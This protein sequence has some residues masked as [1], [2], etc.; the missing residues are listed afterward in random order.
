MQKQKTL[1]VYGGGFDPPH[2]GHDL[3]L[4]I[5]TQTVDHVLVVPCGV[6][7][8]KKASQ[9]DAQTRLQWC[10][11]WLE[12]YGDKVS[13]IDWE[14]TGQLS[15]LTCDLVARVHKEFPEWKRFVAIG[16]DQI[17]DFPSWRGNDI[18]FQ[19]AEL[20]AIKRGGIP[21][22]PQYLQWIKDHGGKVKVVQA[23][24]PPI[25]CS[26]SDIRKAIQEGN[27]WKSKLLPEV[28]ACIA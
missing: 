21:I 5:L 6:P 19:H 26:S 12:K 28:A 11:R 3:C 16:A 4:Q 1:A 22:L 9:T 18:I 17:R 20:L 10:E 7:V 8:H 25:E 2:V 23:D 14:A 15:G 13:L 24:I 27:D